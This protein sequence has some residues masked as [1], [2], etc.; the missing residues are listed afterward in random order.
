MQQVAVLQSFKVFFL[1]THNLLF[2]N[3]WKKLWYCYLDL[4][5][6]LYHQKWSIEKF[7]H[8]WNKNHIWLFSKEISTLY[9]H[10]SNVRIPR[11]VLYIFSVSVLLTS[12]LCATLSQECEFNWSTQAF[13]PGKATKASQPQIQTARSACVLI[14]HR[15]GFE[16]IC[17][18]SLSEAPCSVLPCYVQQKSIKATGI[19]LNLCWTNRKYC[20]IILCG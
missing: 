7:L 12:K 11:N 4:N 18:A 5:F 19:K 3:F 14:P 2:F 15:K 9:V 16:S 20:L 17:R 1:S 10:I 8:F 6:I 13:F